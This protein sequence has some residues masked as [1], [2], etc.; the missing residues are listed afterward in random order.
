M[1]ATCVPWYMLSGNTGLSKHGD[2]VFPPF[3]PLEP[4]PGPYKDGGYLF[5]ALPTGLR[6]LCI[7]VS[8]RPQ[9]PPP[10]PRSPAH[11]RPRASIAMAPC[12]LMNPK[13]LLFADRCPSPSL[14]AM[15]L[16]DDEDD[17]EFPEA[18]TTLS[19]ETQAQ[20]QVLEKVVD[21]T[22]LTHMRSQSFGPWR[23]G[24]SMLLPIKT[25]ADYN[26]L[27]H[28]TSIALSGAQVWEACSSEEPA[29]EGP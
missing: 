23:T 29:Y 12:A 21:M 13:A 6:W 11:T 25:P 10:P 20:A 7:A 17:N 9:Q 28:S 26:C 18:L 14:R 22:V 1:S 4:E 27:C 19:P 15:M 2:P 16:P 24:F 8:P 5:F 3:C